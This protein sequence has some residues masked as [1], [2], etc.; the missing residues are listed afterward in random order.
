MGDFSPLKGKPIYAFIGAQDTRAAMFSE[1]EPTAKRAGADVT[2][3]KYDAGHA[4]PTQHFPEIRQWLVEK[5]LLRDLPQQRQELQAALAAG[6]HGRAFRAANGIKDVTV[7]DSPEHQDAQAAIERLLPLGKELATKV[8]AAPLAEQQR[9][10]LEWKGC[11]FTSPVVAKC[12]ETAASQLARILGQKPV[13]PAFLKKF[14]TMW[15]GFPAAAEATTHYETFASEALGKIA[16]TPSA[17]ARNQALQQFIATWDP[18]P[19][20]GKAREMREEIAR[21]EF[22]AITAIKSK[23]TMRAKLRE[24]VRTYE[25]TEVEQ[26]ARTLMEE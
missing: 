25:G 5:V 22:T 8:L 12:E 21:E 3:L 4:M 23:G 20:A 14:I 18:A 24:F 17:A 1:I 15:D 26:E 9:F 19:S 6:Q 13:S 2:F 11:D 10:V 16:D 7:P